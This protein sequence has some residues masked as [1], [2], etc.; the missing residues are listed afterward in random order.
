MSEF[1]ATS[2]EALSI[3]CVIFAILPKEVIDKTCPV[4]KAED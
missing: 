1:N 3:L 4:C 2:W